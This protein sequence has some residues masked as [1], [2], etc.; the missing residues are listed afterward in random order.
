MSLS[1]DVTFKVTK[2]SK[3]EVKCMVFVMGQLGHILVYAALALDTWTDPLPLLVRCVMPLFSY[4]LVV[5]CKVHSCQWSVAGV[6]Q[7]LVCATTN[8]I[9]FPFDAPFV[10]SITP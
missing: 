6:C 1:I 9:S 10:P 7:T 8:S 4:F 2:K 5:V 3:G